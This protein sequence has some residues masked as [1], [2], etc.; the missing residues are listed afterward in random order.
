VCAG[1]GSGGAGCRGVVAPFAVDSG[2]FGVAATARARP[3]DIHI[4]MHGEPSGRAGAAVRH[5]RCARVECRLRV[6]HPIGRSTGT[7]PCQVRWGPGRSAV[8]QVGAMWVGCEHHP[9]ACCSRVPCAG[10]HMH[11]TCPCLAHH[12]P[13]N[14]RWMYEWTCVR[15]HRL[16]VRGKVRRCACVGAALIGGADPSM[17]ARPIAPATPGPCSPPFCSSR[18][19]WRSTCWQARRLRSRA[20]GGSGPPLCPSTTRSSQ[21]CSR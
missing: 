15:P 16:T 10:S 19:R 6:T 17:H 8:V 13:P 14:T 5:A 7:A 1:Q 20:G 18:P 9:C 12:P 3:R 21:A 2:W 11:A 4:S